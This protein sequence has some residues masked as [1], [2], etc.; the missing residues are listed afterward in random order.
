MWTLKR[1]PPPPRSPHVSPSERDMRPFRIKVSPQV[2][3]SETLLDIPHSFRIV[4]E[5]IVSPTP[6]AAPWSDRRGLG[7][8]AGDSRPLSEAS[9]LS[10]PPCIIVS[11]VPFFIIRGMILFFFF[12]SSYLFLLVVWFRDPD[13]R[14]TR[15]IPGAQRHTSLAQTHTQRAFTLSVKPPPRVPPKLGCFPWQ[16]N[17][18]LGHDELSAEIMTGISPTL[19]FVRIVP[20]ALNE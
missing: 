5:I 16:Q 1:H 20:P 18:L 11:F 15:M 3:S 14:H 6:I 13:A 2:S 9:M 4:P 17:F 7:T 12:F 10:S 19:L 8:C